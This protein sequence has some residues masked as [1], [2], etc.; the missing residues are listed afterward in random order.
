[1]LYHLLR[2]ARSIRGRKI[3]TI[4]LVSIAGKATEFSI[5]EEISCWV[6]WGGYG[7]R[8]VGYP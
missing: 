1:M 8:K 2:G 7:V 3:R 4:T 5:A 6:W